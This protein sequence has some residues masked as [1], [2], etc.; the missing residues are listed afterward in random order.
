MTFTAFSESIEF[1]DNVLKQRSLGL[2]PETSC[3]RDRDGTTG[4]PRHGQQR[5]FST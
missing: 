4:P 1:Y 2:E 5:G 3:L